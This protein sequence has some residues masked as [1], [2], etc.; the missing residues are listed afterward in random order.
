MGVDGVGCVGTIVKNNNV[1]VLN[2]SA[3]TLNAEAFALFIRNR[4]GATV[5]IFRFFS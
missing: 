3:C 4:D 5:R 1:D 2:M